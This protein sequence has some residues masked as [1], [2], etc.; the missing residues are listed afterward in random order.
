[1]KLYVEKGHP[2]RIA[3]LTDIHLGDLP[4]ESDERSLE[5]I[6]QETLSK[7]EKTLDT[8]EFDLFMITG[9]LVWG[10]DNEHPRRDLKPLYTLLNKYDTPVAIT[11]GNHDT[12]G[13]FG[14]D[15]IRDYE[16]ELHHLA[17]KTNV[18][19]S[20]EKENYTLEILDQATGE[21]VNKLFV[22]DS[23]MYYRD[24]RISQY[25]AIDHDQIDWYVD[26]SKSYA[27]PTFDVGFMHIPL[28]EYKKVDSEKITG[29]FGEPVCS[30]D[31]NSGLFYEILNQDNIKVLVAGHDHFNNFSGNYAGIQLNYGNVTGYN[32]KS[33]L[34]RGIT[35][36]DL[37]SDGIQRKNILFED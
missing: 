9:D 11:Y 35:Q 13:P 7:L 33:D 32:C 8:H 16:N 28:P 18:F 1:M 19:M 6:N 21:I 34:K 30:A 4:L 23:G 2:F 17:K 37:Y 25:E 20:G 24:S 5:N 14:R 36:Y 22:W 10:K 29:S 3:Q 12:E 27:A 26:T 31:I 15:Y